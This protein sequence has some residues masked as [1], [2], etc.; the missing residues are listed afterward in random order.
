[1]AAGTGGGGGFDSEGLE[2]EDIRRLV[3]LSTFSSLSRVNICLNVVVV[4]GSG[5]PA[6]AAAVLTARA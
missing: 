6:T 3:Y 5:A 1:M 4:Y 2:R